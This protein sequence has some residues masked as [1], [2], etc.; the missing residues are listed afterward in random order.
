[1]LT[2]LRTKKFA[3]YVVTGGQAFVRAYAERMCASLR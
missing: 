1:M 3:T 2:N